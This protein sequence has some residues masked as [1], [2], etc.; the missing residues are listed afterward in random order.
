MAAALALEWDQTEIEWTLTASEAAAR[1]EPKIILQYSDVLAIVD[2]YEP[3]ALEVE[4]VTGTTSTDL[5]LNIILWMGAG[6]FALMIGGFWT[7]YSSLDTSME[8]QRLEIK[9][10]IRALSDGMHS[11]FEKSDSKLDSI[12]TKLETVSTSLHGEIANLRVRQIQ[13]EAK[14]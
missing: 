2:A 13:V 9:A 12:G 14:Q 8:G 11:R 10:D 5:K 3:M 4:E 7:I 1:L 6:L